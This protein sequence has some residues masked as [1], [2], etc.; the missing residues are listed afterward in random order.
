MSRTC[1]GI[2]ET[3]RFSRRIYHSIPGVLFCTACAV[4]Q[5]WEITYRTELIF[6]LSNPFKARP[7]NTMSELHRCKLLSSTGTR[8]GGDLQRR[9]RRVCPEEGRSNGLLA[10]QRWGSLRLYAAHRDRCTDGLI[11]SFVCPNGMEKCHQST[12]IEH[13][14]GVVNK[15]STLR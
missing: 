3:Q 15:Q 7:T 9:W 2:N 13:F 4:I 14:H 6:S 10:A 5:M 12:W 1:Y 8:A 11:V